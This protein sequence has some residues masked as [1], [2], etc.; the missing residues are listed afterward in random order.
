[1]KKYL[2]ILAHPNIDNSR[3]NKIIISNLKN[4]DE[5]YI[6]DL[7]KEYKDFNIDVKREQE[8]LLQYDN[9]IF[10]FPFYWYNITPLLK[11]WFDDVITAGFAYH[12]EDKKLKNKKFGVITTTGGESEAYQTGGRNLFTIEHFLSHIQAIVNMISGIYIKPF[13]IHKASVITD[14]ELNKC[15]NEALLYI[16]NNFL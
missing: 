2:V 11:K 15:S 9:I 14:E 5:F 6:H 3:A 7:Y 10:E 4:N 1:M 12:T 8:L 16:K 13:S